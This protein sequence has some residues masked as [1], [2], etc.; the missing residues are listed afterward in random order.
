MSDHCEEQEMEAEALAAIF[1]NAFEIIDEVQPFKWSI[2][3]LPV[4]CAGDEIEEEARNHVGIK[5]IATIP[6]EYPES[7][8]QLDV[9]IIKGLTDDHRQKLVTMAIEESR[10]NEGM[11]AI[12]AICEAL[13]EWLLDNNAKGLDDASMHAT[14]FRKVKEEE[15]KKKLAEREF[16]AQ[17]KEEELTQAE[18]EEQAVRQRRAEGTPCTLENFEVWRTAFEKELEEEALEEETKMEGGKKQKEKREDKSDRITGFAHF[19]GKAGKAV[20]LD[21]IEKAAAEAEDAPI[22]PEELDV[23]EDLFDL[24]DDEDL[25]DLD[26]EEPDDFD[27]PDI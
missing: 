11:P 10:N 16:E 18:M 20:N 27:E 5:L 17:K 6:E 8:P 19:S 24:D 21:E 9:E 2:K 23:D 7:L 14:F 22:D 3:L 12:F 1:D 13:R 26:F 25:D 15:Q 4:D